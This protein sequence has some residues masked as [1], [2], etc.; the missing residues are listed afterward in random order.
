MS[1]LVLQNLTATLQSDPPLPL[2]CVTASVTFDETHAPYGEF[3]LSVHTP[4]EADAELID[5]RE[6]L[7]VTVE[8]TQDWVTPPRPAQARSF[9]M[10]LHART[11]NHETGDT[12]LTLRTDEAKLIDDG[13]IAAAVNTGAY[14]HESSLRGIVNFILAGIGAVL[15]AG[16]DDADFT[17]TA[18]ATNLVRNPRVAAANTDWSQAGTAA[19][20]S[21]VASGGPAGAASF[22]RSTMTGANP[23][24][25]TIS[26][27][28]VGIQ[29]APNT[30]YTISIWARCSAS[31]PIGFDGL[32]YNAAGALLQDLPESPVMVVANTWTR[33]TLVFTSAATAS[34]MTLRVFTSA[35]I[36]AGVTFD[37]TG[38]RVSV[39]TGAHD[40]DYFDGATIDSHYTYAWTG[41]ANASNS[42]RTRLDDR[43]IDLL[44]RQPGQASWDYLQPLVQQA[45]LRL[46]CDEQ[47]VW[48][49]VDSNSY[50]IDGSINIAQAVNLTSGN[51]TIDLGGDWATGVVVKYTWIDATGATQTR[52]DAAGTA[53][54][55]TLIEW[56]RP[57]VGPGAAAAILSRMQGKGRTQDL[58]GIAELTATPGQF[59]TAS[60][61]DSPVQTGIAAAV[62]FTIPDGLMAVTTRG[63]LDTLP[64]SWAAQDDAL[65]W[66]AVDAGTTWDTF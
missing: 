57:Y 10:L 35:N 14:A 62:T 53:T 38:A 28:K 15:A 39:T 7:R 41:A 40:S 44:D 18:N 24:G 55:V 22:W 5:P 60:P 37:V 64:G 27:D 33:F 9:D 12:D 43:P 16:T 49:L 17:R 3:Q 50:T 61:P 46:F 48:R 54:K 36:G 20:A 31:D 58:G 13:L 29:I 52:Y 2:E 47:R 19:N 32:V 63:L 26:I 25:F 30:A 34:Q 65:V 66:D 6:G 42:T 23:G 4:A 59:T 8:V 1:I 21:L 45:G 11:F 51:D 56:D